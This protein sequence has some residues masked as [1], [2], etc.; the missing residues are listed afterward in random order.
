MVADVVQVDEVNFSIGIRVAKTSSAE[1]VSDI[2][3]IKEIDRA[4]F[5][6]VS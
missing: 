5:I 1:M 6:C 2:V 4:I 3:E